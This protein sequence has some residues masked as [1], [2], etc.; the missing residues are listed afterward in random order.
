MTVRRIVPPLV[1]CL[2]M[3]GIPRRTAAFQE[4]Q[5]E[6]NPQKQ[7]TFFAG[8]VLEFSG[9]KITITRTV[10]GKTQKRAFRITPDTKVEGRLRPKVRVTVGYVTDDD[11]DVAMRIIVRTSQKQK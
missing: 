9:E 7:D 6:A 3:A 4:A 8:N 2:V 5:Q 11:G 10:L 1:L